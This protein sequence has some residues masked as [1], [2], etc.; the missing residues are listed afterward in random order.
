MLTHVQN[1]RYSFLYPP[2]SA[3]APII[4]ESSATLQLESGWVGSLTCFE[5]GRGYWVASYTDDLNFN[6][7]L[8]E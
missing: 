4:G 5:P 6:L 8:L 2:L 7:C 3:I 1:M